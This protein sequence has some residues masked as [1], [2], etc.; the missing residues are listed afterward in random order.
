MN[1]LDRL[2]RIINDFKVGNKKL[3]FEDKYPLTFEGVTRLINEKPRVTLLPDI[4]LEIIR[5]LSEARPIIISLKG[6]VSQ[7]DVD[8]IM[9]CT[10]LADEIL[11]KIIVTMNSAQDLLE[12]L[13][14]KIVSASKTYSS[15]FTNPNST[16]YN[17]VIYS[18][19]VE[20]VKEFAKNNWNTLT[21][22]E[23]LPLSKEF[24]ENRFN[25]NKKALFSLGFKL[26]ITLKSD[27]DKTLYYT[28]DDIYSL[29]KTYTDITSYIRKYPNG[30]HIKEAN[31]RIKDIEYSAFS[32]CFSISDYNAFIKNYPDS[33][34]IAEAKNR[35]N[36]IYSE[37][38]SRVKSCETVQDCIDIYHEF[39][40]DPDYVIDKK[41][42]SLCCKNSDYSK[43]AKHFI[44]YRNNAL[45][46]LSNAKRKKII[47]IAVIVIVLIIIISATYLKNNNYETELYDL[48]SRFMRSVRSIF[49][50]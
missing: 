46:I 12:S 35:K 27:V 13:A 39:D 50:R 14:N 26:G 17:R 48:I 8:L 18:N 22:L 23:L 36:Q 5:T 4:S 40:S 15:P 41:A 1:E 21:E 34:L 47:Y 2:A 44:C 30:K 16:I 38:I 42:Y 11:N 32:K 45:K 33:Y 28:D 25:P 49:Q 19:I 6:K 20:E 31:K 10:K 37:I 7:N 29:C 24:L 9:I 43:Y 3:S